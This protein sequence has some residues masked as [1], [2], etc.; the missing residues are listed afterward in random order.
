MNALLLTIALSAS[1]T[2]YP[3]IYVQPYQGVQRYNRYVVGHK[4]IVY[5]PI[6]VKEVV[7]PTKEQQQEIDSWV[8]K[9]DDAREAWEDASQSEKAQK[10]LEYRKIKQ[11]SDA[12]RAK[13]GKKVS[14]Q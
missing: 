2:V 8:A 3:P 12:A 10:Y 5:Q 14:G 11:K 1:P 7:R 6:I 9:V 4:H 13:I